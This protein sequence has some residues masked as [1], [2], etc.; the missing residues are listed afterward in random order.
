MEYRS[1]R[2]RVIQ[3]VR[4]VPKGYGWN[5]KEAGWNYENEGDLRRIDP[6]ASTNSV[7]YRL[8]PT[9]NT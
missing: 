6:S 1:R 4:V 5:P 7:P 2:I 8:D 9:E 3:R